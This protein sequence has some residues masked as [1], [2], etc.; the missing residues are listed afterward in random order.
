MSLG[1]QAPRP[2]SLALEGFA[3]AVAPASTLARVQACWEQTV[4]P[5]IAA[6]AAPVAERD[7]VLTVRCEAAVWS[8]ELELM[9]A[10]LLGRLNAALG[11][12]LLRRLR[13][14]VG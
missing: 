12:E 11:E 10:E 6:A 5:A 7:G 9:A 4:G 13:C 3:A 8:Q 2:L 1:R 14:R